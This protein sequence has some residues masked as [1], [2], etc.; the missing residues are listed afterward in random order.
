MKRP[1]I[2]GV[3]ALVCLL[4]LPATARAGEVVLK[5][6]AVLTGEIL[7]VNEREVVIDISGL[8]RVTIL[9]DQIATMTGA[10][11]TATEP[12]PGSEPEPDPGSEPEP[13]PGSEVP[14]EPE[15]TPEPKQLE[16][17]FS[18]LKQ[19]EEALVLLKG[20][21][22]GQWAYSGRR[23]LGVPALVGE[24]RAKFV[25]DEQAGV[26]GYVWITREEVARVVELEGHPERRIL[27]L[28]GIVMGSWI[29]GTFTDG[30]SFEGRLDGVSED[31]VVKLTS[32]EGTSATSTEFPLARVRTLDAVVRGTEIAAKLLE[33]IPGEPIR[34]AV[35]G[36]RTPVSGRVIEVD[37]THIHL[38]AVQGPG[39]EIGEV[40]LFLGLPYTEVTVLS[41]AVRQGF[42]GV[43]RGD[44]LS[45]LSFAETE[46][47][48]VR[49]SVTGTLVHATVEEI[50]LV[51]REGLT[52]FP[53]DSV[54]KVSRPPE[55]RIQTLIEGKESSEADTSLAVF[56]GMTKAEV[57]ER[58]GDA[59]GIDVLYDGNR[60]TKVYCRPPFKGP[61][62]GILIGSD[63]A[64]ALDETDLVFDTQIDPKD[65]A[66]GISRMC[67]STLRDYQVTLFVAATGSVLALELQAR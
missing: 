4:A 61:V 37:A 34:L 47:E 56:P 15:P 23:I 58:L 12:D 31:D 30:T 52:V 65:P 22:H 24:K 25:I 13:D 3:L 48:T 60:V 9:R 32:P 55:D 11:E 36:R 29:Q 64:E 10:P 63:L 67:S 45:V 14:P 26:D 27:F 42:K 2:A 44:H 40:S 19:G 21:E 35:H 39:G 46:K 8:G 49:R 18:D 43:S 57:E 33:I 38:E 54:V 66:V 16:N 17:G 59:E 1:A 41:N 20:E 62:F 50:S 5:T 6:G 53:A 51:T 28:S 7:E